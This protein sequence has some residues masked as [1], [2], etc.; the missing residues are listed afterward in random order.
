LGSLPSDE[1]Q[2]GGSDQGYGVCAHIRLQTR[3]VFS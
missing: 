1:G 3:K 2:D